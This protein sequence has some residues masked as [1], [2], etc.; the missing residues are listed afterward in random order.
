MVTINFAN[1]GVRQPAIVAGLPKVLKFGESF[2][3]N[4]GSVLAIPKDCIGVTH[5]GVGEPSTISV[6]RADC[7]GARRII[8]KL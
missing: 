2:T 6:I 8:N 3:H 7:Q 4:N 5:T 1:K